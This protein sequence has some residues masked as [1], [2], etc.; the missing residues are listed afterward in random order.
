MVNLLAMKYLKIMSL[1]ILAMLFGCREYRYYAFKPAD[2]D[3]WRGQLQVQVVGEYKDYTVDGDKYQDWGNPY[4]L[5]F[6]YYFPNTERVEKIE[7][8][9][10]VLK[11]LGSGTRVQLDGREGTKRTDIAKF[12]DK[13]DQRIRLSVA[14]SDLRNHQLAYE[15]YLLTCVVRVHAD[16]KVLE[17]KKIE[18]KLETDFKKGKRS[19]AY[20]A[21]MGI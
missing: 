9:N 21:L 11:G 13:N 8:S 19:D 3:L 12:F 17:E 14:L 1:G 2:L 6:F 10:V 16:G 7:I 18:V 5:L 15:P 4:H 20:D